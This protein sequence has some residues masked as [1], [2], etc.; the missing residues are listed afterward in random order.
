MNVDGSGQRRLTSGGDGEGAPVVAG[1]PAARLH[2]VGLLRLHSGVGVRMRRHRRLDRR[3]GRVGA[4]EGPRQRLPAAL[5]ARR[6]EAALP[7]DRP[8]SRSHHA[9]RLPRKQRR[10]RRETAR[11]SAA[12]VV[13]ASPSGVV[14]DRRTIVYGVGMG[15]VRLH[16]L[17]VG[18]RRARFLAVG[19]SPAWSHDG[20][21]IASTRSSGIWV[22][23]SRGGR[24]RR[25]AA[26]S[27]GTLPF[28]AW[29]PAGKQL[30]YNSGNRLYVVR[31]DG[32]ST[33]LVAQ[34]ATC[35]CVGCCRVSP[36]VWSR[37]GRRPYY[38]S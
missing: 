26:A 14:A 12:L 22:I 21:R 10:D 24:P 1:R 18:G 23:P 33:R 13:R 30:A 27:A 6:F 9:G 37:N 25:V 15:A 17:N 11:S 34:G 29:S 16:L 36:P 20:S 5:V 28:P 3:R 2:G 31:V 4:T 38:W 8:E 35:T 7:A 19:S 32:R